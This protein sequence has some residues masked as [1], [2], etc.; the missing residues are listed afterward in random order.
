MAERNE[1]NS[2]SKIKVFDLNLLTIFEMVFIHSSVSNAAASLGMTPSAV[3]Q[4]LQKLR[5]HFSDPLF[6]RE[7]KGISP[8][9]VAAN[10]HEQLAQSMGQLNKAI[11]PTPDMALKTKF[12][13]YAPPFMSMALLPTVV[14][15]LQNDGMDYEIVHYSSYTQRSSTEEL[16]NFRKADIIFSPSH[17]VSFSTVCT[18]CSVEPMAVICRNDHPRVGDTLTKLDVANERFTSMNLDDA[19]VLTHKVMLN[20]VLGERHFL[21]SSNSMLGIISVVE[22]TDAIG[23]VPQSLLD[24]FGSSFKVRS[25]KT[26]FE[27]L[28]TTIYMIYNKSSLQ[29][30]AFTHMLDRLKREIP[31]A[32]LNRP[33]DN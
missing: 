25:L 8:T 14:R 15:S 20:E 22:N 17:Y 10:L 4:S 16:L 3:S 19:E 24:R 28:K 2:L 27:M 26:E 32:L 13:V 31:T 11:N 5:N 7:G 18:P 9:T 23:V 30:R 1:R 29:N 12:V 6:I 21:F 33:E